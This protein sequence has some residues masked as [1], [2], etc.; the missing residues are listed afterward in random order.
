MIIN[1]T[2]KKLLGPGEGFGDLAL[3]YNS[4]RTGSIQAVDK[5]GLWGIDR[6][7]FRKAVEDISVQ[8]YEAN[9]AFI[10]NIKF[11]SKI[12]SKIILNMNFF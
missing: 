11:F 4:P 3:L 10:E 8:D 9:R 2:P 1:E 5:V 6:V 7:S 12:G